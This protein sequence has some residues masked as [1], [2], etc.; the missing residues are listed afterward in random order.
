MIFTVHYLKT[1]PFTYIILASN[2]YPVGV[3]SVCW[4]HQLRS[5]LAVALVPGSAV[6]AQEGQ[7]REP[8]VVEKADDHHHHYHHNHQDNYYL[9]KLQFSC[10]QEE[11]FEDRKR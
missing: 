9:N 5:R 7:G 10:R 11:G 1:I 2:E 3:W 8:V 4:T 6:S